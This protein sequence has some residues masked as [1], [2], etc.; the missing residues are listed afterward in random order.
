MKELE[1]ASLNGKGVNSNS[2]NTKLRDFGLNIRLE[3]LYDIYNASQYTK[4]SSHF[5]FD[6]KLTK[7]LHNEVVSGLYLDVDWTVTVGAECEEG[8]YKSSALGG[9]LNKELKLIGD[10]HAHPNDGYVYSKWQFS[11]L[12]NLADSHT[13]SIQDVTRSHEKGYFNLIISSEFIMI[14]YNEQQKNNV[15]IPLSNFNK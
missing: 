9:N 4:T 7:P 6:K 2:F 1:D 13:P 3:G 5:Y 10:A 11:I 15:T 14:Q 12:K 8:G